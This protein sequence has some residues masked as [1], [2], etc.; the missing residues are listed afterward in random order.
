[1]S[2]Y[3]EELDY[4]P[5][6]IGAISL[7]RRHDF[8]LKIDVLEIMLGDEHLMSD[9]FTESEIALARLGLAY[10]RE[11]TSARTPAH[12]LDVVVGGLGLGYTAK[13]VLEDDGAGSLLV[14]DALQAIIDWHETGLLPLGAQLCGD[15]RCRMICADFFAAS[16]SADGF[17]PDQPARLFDAI[18]V[19]IDHAPDFHLAP[20]NESFY[21]AVG[22]TQLQTHLAP[23]GIFGLWS[24]DPPDDDFTAHLVGVFSDARAEA[25]TFANPFQDADVTQTI[26]LARK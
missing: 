20:G 6:P 10:H 7:R 17:D 12:K 8:R 4:Q 21:S 23:D 25:V 5:T 11:A 14:V 22:L 13:A 3:F 2:R 19:D 15:A 24:N 1:M 9:L 16:A 26:Y 18:L